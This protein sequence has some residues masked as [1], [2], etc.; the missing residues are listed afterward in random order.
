MPM[1]KID[2]RYRSKTTDQ[3]LAH[4]G[5]ELAEALTA[6]LKSLRF[7]LECHNPELAPADQESNLAWLKR[8]MADVV[9]AYS[10]F[11]GFL[12]D[13]GLCEPDPLDVLLTGGPKLGDACDAANEMTS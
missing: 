8:E 7:G 10:V 11:E 5:E 4:L 6:A 2:E 9:R 12:V 3:A 1:S 13:D